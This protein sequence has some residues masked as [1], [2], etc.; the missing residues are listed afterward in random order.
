M[1]SRM[2]ECFGRCFYEANADAGPFASADAA[3]ILAYSVLM[4]NTD[5]HNPNVRQ[6][7]TVGEFIRNNRGINEKADLPVEFLTKLYTSIVNN[8]MRVKDENPLV[9]LVDNFE[10]SL[11]KLVEPWRSVITD[12][13]ADEVQDILVPN[14]ARME[15][16][17]HV[18]NDCVLVRATAVTIVGVGSP[19]GAPAQQARQEEARRV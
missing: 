6:R 12:F 4:L 7:M 1:I 18:F 11:V 9:P 13:R 3:Y 5:A 15:R 16:H 10:A 14:S 17:I 19:R 8:E 2:M